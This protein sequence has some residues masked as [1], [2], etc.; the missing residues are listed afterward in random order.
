M[1]WLKNNWWIKWLGAGLLIG[2]GFVWSALWIVAAVGIVTTIYLALTEPSIKRLCIGSLT[3]W[4]VKSLMALVW[5]WSTYP[6]DWLPVGEPV[7]QVILIGVWWGTAALWLG[8]GGVVF[9]AGVWLLQKYSVRNIVFILI[10]PLWI[11]SEM[12]GSLIFSIITIGPGGSITTAFSFGYVGYLL[13][14]HEL[15]L[16]VARIAGVYALG[17][18]LVGFSVACVW[19][20]L[21]KRS[22]VP[23]VYVA[24]ILLFLTSFVSMPT[25]QSEEDSYTVAVINTRFDLNDLLDDLGRGRV[26][27]NIESAMQAA[28]LLESDYILLP[29]DSRYFDQQIDVDILRATF[30][31][32]EQNPEVIIV[33]SGRAESNRQSVVQAFVYNGLS[34]KVDL[35]Q[36]RYLVPQGEFMPT[37]YTAGLKLFGNTEIIETVAKNTAFTVGDH[38]DQSSFDSRSPGV[39]F[40][41]ESVS[42]FGVRTIMKERGS[43]PFIAHPVSH[44]WFT[45]PFALWN[46][47]ETML[48]VQAVWNQ[49]YIVSS[50]N[51]V[52]GY[53]V[54]PTGAIVYPKQVQSGDN[55]SLGIVQI[56]R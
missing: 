42:P 31:F 52:R 22:Q 46:Q 18:F 27:A 30:A 35:S 48:Q 6:I 50:G 5:F 41:F 1:A 38:V 12:A 11:L 25:I 55:W 39:L 4:T 49:S 9:A 44:A 43:V 40:C 10:P 19:V 26:Q 2:S 23:Y 56:P 29:E 13:A 32:R 21:H 20:L 53:A 15:L 45:E 54:T 3:T 51:Q 33:D 37:L 47:L 28:L 24:L 17:V 7:I 16:Q 34:G 36:K 14:Q 8:F